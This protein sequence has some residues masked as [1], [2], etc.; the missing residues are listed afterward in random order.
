[1]GL[2][3]L[4]AMLGLRRR[5]AVEIRV[6]DVGTGELR[7]V[8]PATLQLGPVRHQLDDEQLARI[9]RLHERLF[10]MDGWTIEKRADLFS[11]DSDPDR[12]IAIC[13]HIAGLCE[14][15]YED[16]GPLTVDQRSEIYGLLMA[17][18]GVPAA[19]VFKHYTPKAINR[20]QAEHVLALS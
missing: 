15:A 18:C 7:W 6:Q 2:R 9:A 5:P 3:K 13:E 4:F 10:P 1:M 16:L 12:E 11:R 14:R 17:F 20:K 19:E 8:D